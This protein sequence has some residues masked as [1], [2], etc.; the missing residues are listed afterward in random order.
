MKVSFLLFFI[1]QWKTLS[2]V[3]LEA[4]PMGGATSKQASDVVCLL[5]LAWR[6][7]RIAM[8]LSAKIWR[9]GYSKITLSRI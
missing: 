4:T 6:R 8:T 5:L 7:S 2:H 1:S 9:F 3:I